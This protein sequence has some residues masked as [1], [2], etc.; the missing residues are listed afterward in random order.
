[1]KD[2]EAIEASLPKVDGSELINDVRVKILQIPA[3]DPGNIVAMNTKSKRIHWCF[4][5]TGF[6]STRHLS[7]KPTTPFNFHLGGSI[8]HP[9]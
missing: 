1:V 5:T 4:R 2:K 3:A 6:F 9:S 7:G 8:K